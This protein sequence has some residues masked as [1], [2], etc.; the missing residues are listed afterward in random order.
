VAG[1]AVTGPLDLFVRLPLLFVGV[2][3]LL[4]LLLI[5]AVFVGPPSPLTLPSGVH[6]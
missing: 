4:Y 1:Y 6:L 3:G 2:G 5:P